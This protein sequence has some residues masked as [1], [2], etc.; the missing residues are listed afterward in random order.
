MDISC[1]IRH[2]FGQEWETGWTFCN[3]EGFKFYILTEDILLPSLE[4]E[5]FFSLVS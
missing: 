1:G 3:G 2:K 5:P 4:V